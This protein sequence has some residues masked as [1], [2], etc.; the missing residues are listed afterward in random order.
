MQSFLSVSGVA[1]SVE[2]EKKLQDQS[3]EWTQE[4]RMGN[5]YNW[6]AWKTQWR[7]RNLHG[8]VWEWWFDWHTNIKQSTHSAVFSSD[9]DFGN[10]QEMNVADWLDVPLTLLDVRE[11]LIVPR[12]Q[13]FNCTRTHPHTILSM[14]SEVDAHAQFLHMH[15]TCTFPCSAWL[16]VLSWLV[17]RLRGGEVILQEALQVLKGGPF[18]GLFSPAGQHQVMQGFGALCWARHPV[19]TL[20]LVQHLPVHHTC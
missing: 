19:A 18:L 3:G 8:R 17:L 2:A 4:A 12:M 15:D 9:D 5:V 16:Q 1:R 14:H 11:L 6:G 20:H 7:W 13:S 10:G